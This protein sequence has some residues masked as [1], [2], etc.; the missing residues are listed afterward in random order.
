MQLPP[1]AERAPAPIEIVDGHILF[2]ATMMGKEGWILPD[3]GAERSLIDARFAKLAG[4]AIEKRSGTIRTP[5]GM[6]PE[7]YARGVTFEVPGVLRSEGAMAVVDLSP[8]STMK[9][10]EI[11]GVL[12]GDYLRRTTLV[13]R[14]SKRNFQLHPANPDMSSARVPIVPLIGERR[15]VEL[16]GEARVTV[17]LDLG[18]NSAMSLTPEA[19]RRVAPANPELTQVTSMGADG[20]PF[21]FDRGRLPDVA[22]G[23]LHRRDVP[24]RIEPDSRG[25]RLDGRIGYGFLADCDFVLDIQGGKLMVM[26]YRG[27][28]APTPAP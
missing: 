15:A 19:W 12:G 16:H 21:V 4:L 6:L 5:H 8:L 7:Q 9:G 26:P 20:Q 11:I 13:L 1:G 27:A 2:R 18:D 23:R 25:T 28:A 10:R 14:A 17:M 24:V 3:N 22:L